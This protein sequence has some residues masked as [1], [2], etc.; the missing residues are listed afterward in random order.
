MASLVETINSL[1]QR[2]LGRLP[3]WDHPTGYNDKIHWLKV[4]DQRPE[5]VTC[6]DKLAVREWVAERVGGDVLIPL[7]NGY[8][9]VAKCT[10]DSGSAILVRTP[11]ESVAAEYRLTQLLKRPYGVD[12][13]EWAYALVKPRI[14]REEVL[15]SPVD[16]KFHCVNGE[17]RWIQVIWDRKRKAREAIHEPDGRLTSLHMDEK[18]IHD[19]AD[20]IPSD[21][22]L[23]AMS[24]VA[25][26]LARGW[27]Y[28]RVDLYWNDRPMF[29]EM[30]FWPRAGCYKSSDEPIFGQM[31]DI[32]LTERLE[33]IVC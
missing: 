3:N 1:S 20:Q 4:F 10:H 23:Q 29:G 21:Y 24:E 13:G 8:P 15:P 32:D 17:V 7:T 9:C 27:R 6:C 33:P 2:M 12:K 11:M 31:L 18:M 5:H 30:T 26:G 14:I 19:E 16:Y 25:A 28:V 22:A